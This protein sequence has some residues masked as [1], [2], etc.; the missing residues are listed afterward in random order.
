MSSAQGWFPR[1]IE[2]LRGYTVR[3]FSHD[4][5]AGLTVGLVALPL[6][7]AFAI[8]S[9]VP[10]QAG[11]YTAVVAGFLISALGG[12]RTQ[13]GGPTGAFVVIVAGIVVKFGLGGLALVGIMAGFLLLIM[14]VTGL[15]AA[16]KYIP[17]PV[18]IGFTN[19]IALLIAS[20]QIKDFFGMKT[21][22]V[23]SE[24]FARIR[25]LLHYAGTMRWP[26]VAM[27]AASL[28]IILL[29]PR[30]TKR[31][32]GSI[33]ALLLS[34]ALVAVF[35]LPIETIGS[36]FGGIPQG[37][38]HFTLPDFHAEHILPLLP[39][40]FTVALLAAVE[41]LLSAVV[42]DGMSGDRHN[43]NVELI[44]QGV[45]NIASPLFGGIPATGA[46]ARTA[47][48]IRS[49]AL[50]PVAGMVHALTLLTVLLVAAPLARFVPLATLAAVLFVVAYNM[51]EW[52]EIGTILRL[53]KTDIAVWF[54][55]F[56]L[57][58]F[59]DLTV[60]VG[61]GMTLA[62]L[63]YIYRIAE[64]TTVA[65]VTP[66]YLEDGQAHILQD[67]DIPSNV[68][69]LRIHG[70]FLFGT[71]EKLAEATRDLKPFE[72]VVILRL[73]NMTALDATGI[74]ALE[75]FS[76]RLHKAGKTLLLCGARDQPSRLISGS[77]FLKHVGAESVLPHVQAALARAREVQ[78]DF[79]GVGR[80]LALELEHRPL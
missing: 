5:V 68:T 55:T 29:W 6:A 21:P 39:S 77:D 7:M 27:A 54:T 51:G 4:V 34:T 71:T 44:A 22:P 66:E 13:I 12:S 40:A 25:M 76:A 30:L 52:R 33:V 70:P 19:G 75:Q 67:K 37:F 56:A 59:A 50:T 69:I 32:P 74:H 65:P 45:A 23:P 60:A 2:C 41:S 16:V 47:T 15:G 28:A 57:T 62:A 80:E 36:K 61:V 31:L 38:P 64:T 26:T 79:A 17:R 11:L 53:S 43:S 78:G 49:G 9:G 20:T 63:L 72:D 46:I 48:N 35:Q 24:F 18:T 42:A 3:Q 8:A 73:R 10:P 1:S 58:V 14:G